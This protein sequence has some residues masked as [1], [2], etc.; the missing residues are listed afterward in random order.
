[1]VRAIG[2]HV[3]LSFSVERLLHFRYAMKIAL[4]F[5]PDLHLH[6]GKALLGPARE[7]VDQLFIRVGGKPA[8]AI[9]RNL[10]PGRAQ[11]SEQWKPQ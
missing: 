4:W 8:A 7:L 10:W 11:Q 3:Q 1:M 6:A 5:A 2:I 9:G